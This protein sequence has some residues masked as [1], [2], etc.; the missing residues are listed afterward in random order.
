[1]KKAQDEEAA[2]KYQGQQRRVLKGKL[3]VR[4]KQHKHKERI[5]LEQTRKKEYLFP[6]CFASAF[7]LKNQNKN[8]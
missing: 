2:E 8:C 7:S 4:G 5:S 1:M 6:S 3:G